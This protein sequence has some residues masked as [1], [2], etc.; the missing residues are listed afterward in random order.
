[1]SSLAGG[2]DPRLRFSV[3]VPAHRAAVVL[4][5]TLGALVA[6][7]LPRE[8]WELVVVDDG[9]DDQTRD[10]AAR[11]ADRVVAL[12]GPPGGPGKARNA[13]A[14]VA[15]GDWLVFMD[16][17]V[18][19]HPDTLRRFAESIGAAPDVIAVFGSYDAQPAAKG[20]ITEYRNLVHRYVHLRGAGPASTFWAGCGAVRRDWFE[21]VGGFD[22]ERYP[23]PQIEDIELGQRL[24]EQGGRIL[25]DPTIQGTHLKRWTMRG[26]LATD[27]LDRGIPWVRLMLERRARLDRSLNIGSAEPVKVAL[28]G[29]ALG[30]A[31]L[32]LLL[33]DP[34]F[35]VVVLV[36]AI[37]LV[38][39]NLDLYRWF[40]RQRGVGF[41]LGTIPLQLA[42]YACNVVSA[43]LGVALHVG[44]R[45]REWLR[46]RRYH[47]KAAPS[48]RPGSR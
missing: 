11:F 45:I 30:A 33:L 4:P 29:V 2:S 21:R 48:E 34:R 42:Y 27:I 9:S 13:G 40:A 14:R 8:E 5:E 3:V 15:R 26:V 25:L 41:A 16:A 39:W 35:L 10:V 17:D 32:S 46:G 18:R 47:S 24:R 43:G 12:P 20:L 19:V 44:R 6:S 38:L 36:A 22:A 37:V 7:D 28:T 23:R 31:G 1:M